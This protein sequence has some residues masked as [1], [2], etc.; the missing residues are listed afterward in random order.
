L[1]DK[2]EACEVVYDYENKHAMPVTV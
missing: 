2:S 1:S